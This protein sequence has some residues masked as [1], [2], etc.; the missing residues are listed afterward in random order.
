MYFPRLLGIVQLELIVVFSF[1]HEHHGY[2]VLH[3]WKHDK[4]EMCSL[5]LFF[6]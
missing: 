6:L 4:G 5:I 1:F 3:L 2:S